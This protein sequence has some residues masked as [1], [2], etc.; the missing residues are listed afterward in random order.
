M[1]VHSIRFNKDKWTTSQARDWVDSHGFKRIKH[2]DNS[3]NFYRYR[4]LPPE[5]FKSFITKK[6]DN[7]INIVF[8][9]R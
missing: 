3:K 5:M 8:G 6:Y 2:V 1:E 7:G 9:I 4:I